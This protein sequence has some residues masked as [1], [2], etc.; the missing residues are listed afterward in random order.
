MGPNHVAV[1]PVNLLV[2]ILVFGLFQL[3]FR[4]ASRRRRTPAQPHPKGP[5]HLKPKSG[6]DCPFCRAEQLAGPS[7]HNEEGPRLLPPPWR[8]TRSSRG[9]R[10]ASH[11][12]GFA[13]HTPACPYYDIPDQTRH[14][15]VADGP[16]GKHEP[17]PALRCQAC[18]HKFTVRRQTVLYRLKT[19][20][21]RVADALTFLAE[22]VD[23]S[24][25]ERVWH[26]REGTLRTWLTRAGLHAKKLQARIFQN[27]RCAH[28]QLDELWAHVRQASQ[29][30]WVWAALDATT[31]IVPVLRLGPRTLH[32]AYAVVHE[33][34]H[35]LQP[36]FPLPVFTTD[37]L[38]LYFYA[39]TAHFGHWL[40]PEDARKPVWQIATDF[41]YGQVEGLLPRRPLS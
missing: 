35:R 30:V 34:H 25:L 21:A 18:G 15:L 31:K 1:A 29:D 16:D 20:S 13:C 10:K 26:I 28:I 3:V 5:C 11:T 39:L 24:V 38:G 40:Q 22:G 7:Y 23:V 14:A 12:E 19:H 8:S 9:R 32:L 4:L 41:V 33:R 36:G 17:I 27:L 37:G 6:A 2:L